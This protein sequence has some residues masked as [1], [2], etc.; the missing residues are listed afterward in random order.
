MVDSCL[1]VAHEGK[2]LLLPPFIFNR[3]WLLALELRRTEKVGV[4]KTRETEIKSW[5]ERKVYRGHDV[6]MTVKMTNKNERR[7]YVTER[8][9]HRIKIA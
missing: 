5:E 1:G 2:F 9:K 7:E 4:Q 3:F 8:G 6:I